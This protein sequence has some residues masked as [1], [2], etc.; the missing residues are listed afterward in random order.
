MFPSMTMFNGVF[1]GIAGC[2]GRFGG[3]GVLPGGCPA[4]N[5]FGQTL[6]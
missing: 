1:A 6:A 4:T 3:S 2:E 5:P